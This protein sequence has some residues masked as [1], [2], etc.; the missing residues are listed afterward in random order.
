MSHPSNHRHRP[1]RQSPS[2]PLDADELMHIAE[3]CGFKRP[4]EAR[5]HAI[6]AVL[7]TTGMRARELCS[8]TLDQLH[9]GYLTVPTTKT[10]H[11]REIRLT[12]DT[13]WYVRAYIRRYRQPADEGEQHIFLT[14]DGHSLDVM[15]L[16]HIVR[17][18]AN[19]AQL[20]DRHVTLA[21]IRY[22][23]GALLFR[24]LK[25]GQPTEKERSHDDA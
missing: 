13:E 4:I 11:T 7:T 2:T 15:A 21:L 20:S 22:S 25:A 14:Q 8:L 9:E 3:G 18:A 19:C 12:Y 16:A 6:L 5:D 1:R 24:S 23:V 17:V 10:R